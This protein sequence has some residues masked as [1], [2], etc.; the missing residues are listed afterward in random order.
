M[1]DDNMTVPISQAITA[2]FS[3][4]DTDAL[5]FLDETGTSNYLSETKFQESLYLIAAGKKPIVSTVFGLAGVLFL[6]KDYLK[7]HNE[8]RSLKVQHFGRYDFALHEYDIREMKKTPFDIL[9]DNVKWQGF[10][11]DFEMLIKKTNFRVIV[12]TIDKIRMAQTYG[13]PRHPYQYSLHV[14]LERVSNEGNSFGKTCRIVAENRDT[15]LN[16]ELSRE[17]LR[18]Q[19]SGG[20]IDGNQTVTPDQ[21]RARFDPQIVFLKKQDCVAGLELA[22]LAAGPTTRW[23]HHLKGSLTRDIFPIISPKLRRSPAGNLR[24][25]GIKCLPDYHTNCPAK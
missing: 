6:R 20:A 3:P 22:D 13:T 15:G 18:L 1:S 7:F 8:M 14:I 11:N 9:R 16:N 4:R 2:S 12:A 21:F 5:L 19:F 24:G 23:L 17:L 10:Y 25:Y